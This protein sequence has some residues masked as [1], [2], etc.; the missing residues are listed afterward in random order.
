MT[1]IRTGRSST[2]L[3]PL[4]IKFNILD[5]PAGSVLIEF[6][7]TKVIC[8]IS[9]VPGVPPFLRN[10]GQG[11]LTAEYSMLP[12][13]TSSRTSRE[14]VTMKRSGRSV[15]ISR[16]IGRS[17]RLV[18]DLDILGER[19]IHVD[20]DVIQADGGTRATSI[21]QGEVR[22]DLDAAEDN[23]I[24]TD[25]NFVFTKNGDLVELQGTAEQQSI[26]WQ[27]ITSLHDESKKAALNLF[28]ILEKERL[29]IIVK[30]NP[31]ITDN[32]LEKDRKPVFAKQLKNPIRFIKKDN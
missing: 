19:T 26:N 9:L 24:E 13:A 1:I 30:D 27:A 31:I 11:W 32:N 12:A 22:V 17:L 3:R 8:A 29:S 25:I 16:M 28:D 15:E 7:K 14:S 23:N 21:Y 10:K 6:G 2:E 18:V 20:C 4:T 5:F